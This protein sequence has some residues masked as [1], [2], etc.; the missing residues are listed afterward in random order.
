MLAEYIQGRHDVMLDDMD[1]DVVIAHVGVVDL[2]V[3]PVL[4]GETIV[5]FNACTE[6]LEPLVTL[7]SG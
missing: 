6:F 5:P 2:H 7:D 3:V 4:L 1:Q